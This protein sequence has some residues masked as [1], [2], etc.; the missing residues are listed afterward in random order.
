M[1][2]G[3]GGP[4]HLLEFGPLKKKF[5]LKIKLFVQPKSEILVLKIIVFKPLH[6]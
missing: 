4:H 5:V 1:V 6:A 3:A 2:K